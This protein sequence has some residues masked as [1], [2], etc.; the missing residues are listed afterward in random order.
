MLRP[1]FLRRPFALAAIVVG[2]LAFTSPTAQA[3]CGCSKAPPLP[4]AIRPEATYAGTPVTLFGSGITVGQLY[5]VIFMAMDGTKATVSSVPAV[6]KRDLADAV[7]KAQLI[8]KIPSSLSPGP[9]GVT[10]NRAG[11]T[12]PL[13]SI[14]DASFTVTPQP[15]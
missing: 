12:S 14:P 10:V 4:A 9:V 13:L 8:V 11:Q 1:R 2:L 3:G 15:I 7:Y 6:S 5:D